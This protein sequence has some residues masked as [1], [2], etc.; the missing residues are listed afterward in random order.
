MGLPVAP[1]RLDAR[2]VGTAL[3]DRTMRRLVA[4]AATAP[5]IHNTQPWR[6]LLHPRVIDVYADPHRALT[7]IDP[8]GRE[9]YLSCGAVTLNLRVAVR[10]LGRHPRV[11][12]LP[13][14]DD[15]GHVATVAVGSPAPRD[16]PTRLLEHAI[17]HRRSNRE[18]YDDRA[19]A[20]HVLDDLA[21]AAAAEGAGHSFLGRDELDIVRGIIRDAEL[22]WSLNAAYRAELRAWTSDGGR[23]D[24]V[25]A[26]AFG[27]W[28]AMWLLPIR[29]FAA[30]GVD[31]G[32]RPQQYEAEPTLGLLSTRGDGPADWL[33]AG[34]ALQHVLLTATVHGL[35]ASLFS[36]P[37]E[38]PE[39]RQSLR[40]QT[41][42]ATPQM[43]LRVGYGPRVPATPR[44]PP[45]DVIL[46]A[47]PP[48][49]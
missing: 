48:T 23:D 42:G 8:D 1:P 22:R 13:D 40:R 5:S 32:R 21:D 27:P 28:D 10:A 26:A 41:D 25:P 34:M 47:P 38:I 37:V 33:R 7:V 11:A 46:D 2:R 29:D 36:Q 4:T 44:R 19:P 17:W 20:P 45:G 14:P 9:L 12:L 3:D 30:S 35:A 49:R 43:V 16:R 24:G 15:E 31:P 6:F 18:P 39:L